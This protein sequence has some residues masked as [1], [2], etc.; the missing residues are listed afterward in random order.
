MRQKVE[1]EILTA[2]VQDSLSAGYRLAVSLEKGYDTDEM[3]LGS[4]DEA[5]ILEAALA[6]DECHIFVQSAD[7]PVLD[8]G[9]VLSEG[10]VYFVYG[11][12]GYDVI[13]DYLISPEPP[14]LETQLMTRANAISESYAD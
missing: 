4:R 7:G 14:E 2:F 11:N 1:R 10:W 3:L 9:L 6:G 12:D 13:S 8:N 5:A